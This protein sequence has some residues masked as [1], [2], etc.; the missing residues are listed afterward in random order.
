MV[1]RR[2]QQEHSDKRCKE[3]RAKRTRRSGELLRSL[4]LPESTSESFPC[5]KLIGDAHVEI[6]NHKG[7]L[8]LT[9]NAIRLYTRLGILRVTGS[10]LE[11]RNADHESLL[12]DGCICGIEYEKH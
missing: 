9:Q 4:S 6:E 8:E 10:L 2:S 12:I 5:I 11:V 1:K 3:S 7:V